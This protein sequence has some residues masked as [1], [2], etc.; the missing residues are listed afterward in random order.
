MP[1]AVKDTP[2]E[3]YE[4]GVKQRLKA[5]SRVGPQAGQEPS[6]GAA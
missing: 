5:N 3:E 6:T 4:R 1:A 2:F